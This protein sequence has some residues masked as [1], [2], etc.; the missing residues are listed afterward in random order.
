[1][2]HCKAGP[3]A[4]VITQD[5]PNPTSKSPANAGT[6]DVDIA[7]QLDSDDVGHYLAH[8]GHSLAQSIYY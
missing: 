1:M 7:T 5:E 6:P 8:I 4:P 3:P 2:G